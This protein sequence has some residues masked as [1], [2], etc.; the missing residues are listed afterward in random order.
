MA[1]LRIEKG[2]KLR[3]SYEFGGGHTQQSSAS[4][5]ITPLVHLVTLVPWRDNAAPAERSGPRKASTSGGRGVAFDKNQDLSSPGIRHWETNTSRGAAVIKISIYQTGP[6]GVASAD[7]ADGYRNDK[8]TIFI[9]PRPG[10][11][12]MGQQ[13]LP[14]P[15]LQRPRLPRPWLGI[16]S[17]RR[18]SHGQITAHTPGE[19]LCVYTRQEIDRAVRLSGG[20]STIRVDP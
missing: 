1:A 14:E 11:Q 5:V 18:Y 10:L 17:G 3:Y 9:I 15:Y 13:Y 12:R 4:P 20:A 7:S 19:A 6:R 2:K 8:K 16:H